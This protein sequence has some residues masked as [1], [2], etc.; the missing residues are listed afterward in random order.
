MSPEAKRADAEEQEVVVLL[1]AAAAALLSTKRKANSS[2]LVSLQ[3][4]GNNS[5]LPPRNQPPLSPTTPC[6]PSELLLVEEGTYSNLSWSHPSRS[7]LQ[8]KLLPLSISGNTQ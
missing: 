3:L 8:S 7:V 6:R 5:V 1:V 4:Q 2:Q